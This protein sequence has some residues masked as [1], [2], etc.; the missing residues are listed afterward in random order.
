MYKTIWSANVL[1]YLINPQNKTLTFK[2][3]DFR[4]AFEYEGT[5]YTKPPGADDIIL[6]QLVTLY[7]LQL[8]RQ[9]NDFKIVR[10][11]HR[12][13]RAFCRV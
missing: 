10:W 3:G 13:L 5:K 6:P 8:G 4:P 2:I 11:R 1:S 12:P 9:L 7:K